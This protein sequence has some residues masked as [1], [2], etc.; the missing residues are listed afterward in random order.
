MATVKRTNSD[1][2]IYA[3]TVTIN[4]NLVVVGTTS[5][6]ES[7]ETLVYDNFLTLAAGQSGAPTIDAGIEV[8]RGDQPKVGLRWKED[9]G[10][11]Q[12]TNDGVVWK[13]FSRT[14]VQEDLDPHLGGNLIV[15]DFTITADPGRNVS[16][17][18]VI[19]IPHIGTDANATPAHSTIYAKETQAG[20]TGLFVSNDRVVGH[21]LITKRKA[22]IYSIIF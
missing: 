20:D 8:E 1:Y 14:I 2:E 21:E 5:Q 15:N 7:V 9:V 13:S 12:Y 16:I 10:T 22:F 4:G 19:V 17:G 18:P 3:P 6:I 11:W